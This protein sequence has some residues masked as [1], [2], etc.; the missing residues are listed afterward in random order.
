[1]NDK[2]SSL[3]HEAECE[4]N[5][6]LEFWL[7]HAQDE[8]HGGFIGEI[9]YPLVPVAGAPKALV[10][11]AR[12][13]WTYAAA[14][15]L[16][17][18]A[19]YAALA[20]RAFAYIE[21]CFR[22]REYGGYYWELQ[23]DGTPRETGKRLYGQ[24]FA[25]YGLAE[26]YRAFGEPAAL[27]A[28]MALF[29]LLEQRCH[30]SAH[31]GYLEVFAR[32]WTHTPFVRG[33]HGRPFVVH[34]SMNAHLHMLEAYTCLYRVWP[35]ETLR[36][37]LTGLVRIMQ[38]R[39]VHPDTARFMLFFDAAWQ[40]LSDIE[41]YGHDIEGSWLLSEAAGVLGDAELERSV[42]QTSL[43][44]A[45]AT[46]DEGVD[47]DGGV[48]HEQEPGRGL[49][50]DKV[51]WPQAEAAVGLLNAYQLSG[52]AGYW[53]A[54]LRTWR[55]ITSAIKDHEHGEWY[56]RVS[57]DGKPD[58]SDPKTS[59]WKCPYHNGRACMELMERLEHLQAAALSSSAG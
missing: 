38:E 53:E 37:R 36:R 32:D 20:D 25:L 44:M 40:P 14:Y 49:D 7:Q 23:A 52:E 15:R 18:D 54:A 48:F 27:E 9:H 29:R 35:D 10:L 31:D 1:M 5:S 3:H 2:F 19:R 11:H 42:R 57:R 46:L 8:V 26:Y 51:W 50:A 22:D 33:G 30:D 4:L 56:W 55:F 39:I 34:K 6:I 41:S 13:L 45:Q 59:A 16:K 17:P 21:R 47:A 24:S 12:I 28:A 58:L 43:R